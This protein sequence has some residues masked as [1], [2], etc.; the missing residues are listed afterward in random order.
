MPDAGVGG[1]DDAGAGHLGPPAE[2]EV[3]PHGHD[4]RVVAAELGEEVGAHEG[5]ATGSEEDV[6]DGVVLA[7]V[8]L[9]G[10]DP[11]HGRS[12]LVDGHAHVHQAR[13][14]RPS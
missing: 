4:G 9:V 12:R 11:L 7:V 1:D 13:R 5:A 8:D 10:V 2:V 6:T 3:L 14:G